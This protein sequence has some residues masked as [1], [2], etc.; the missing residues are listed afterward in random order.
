MNVLKDYKIGIIGGNGQVGCFFRN[1]FEEDGIKVLV[2]DLDTNLSNREVAK[3]SDIVII[4]VPIDKTL[5]VITEVLPEMTK[6]KLFMDVTSIKSEPVEAMLNSEA[7]VIGMHPMFDPSVK[8]IKNQTI[9]LTPARDRRRWLER[10]KSYFQKKQVFVKVT[11]S[12][13]H[14]RMMSLIQVLVHFTT[15]SVGVTVSKLGFD[16]KETLDYTSP[17]YRLE[18]GIIARIFA[19]NGGMY[20]NIF[21]KNLHTTQVLEE[22]KHSIEE[23]SRL[24]LTK[25]LGG[26]IE[27]FEQTSNFF[28]SF[29]SSAVNES[30]YLISKLVEYN[31]KK[32]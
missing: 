11:T 2:S 20:G 25:D 15:V 24:I 6:D 31:G 4:S 10:I 21:M 30:D 5:V 12:E 1:L 3:R 8:S 13:E 26:F 29:K 23:V 16:L 32:S 19:Q 27:M 18:L 28:N 9:I 22:Y 17:I 7:D 14:D